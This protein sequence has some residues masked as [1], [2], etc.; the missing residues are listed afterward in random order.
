V[1]TALLGLGLF[2]LFAAVAVGIFVVTE[3]RK[4]IFPAR[5]AG[6]ATALLR[7][8]DGESV[9]LER[10]GGP[11]TEAWFLPA[12]GGRRRPGPVIL[13]THGNGELIDDWAREFDEPRMWGASV[14]LVEYPGYGRSGGSPSERSISQTML[15]AYD[16]A[17][18]RPEVDA[19]R[20]I[21]YGRSL[22]GGAACGLTAEREVA[23]LVLESTFTSV[24]AIA[25]RFGL[26]GFLVLD[27][28]DNRARVAA[29]HRPTLVIHGEQDEMIPVEQARAL[30]AAAPQSELLIVGDCGHNDCPRPWPKLREFLA[31]HRL[32]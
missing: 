9:W 13:Y 21:A 26:P 15:A 25:R 14:L 4:L 20:I 29:F 17:S 12:R 6:D 8:V 28:F 19:R 32:L 3:E 5:R 23:A 18:A 2:A 10:T 11:R 7:S 1:R 27:P 31:S 22:G 30:H 24:R 16:W